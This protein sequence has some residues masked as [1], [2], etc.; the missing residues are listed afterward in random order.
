M[1]TDTYLSFFI[2]FGSPKVYKVMTAAKDVT[3]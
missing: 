1:L 2:D 3:F